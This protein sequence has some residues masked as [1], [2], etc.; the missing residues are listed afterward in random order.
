MK[1][2][3]KSRDR[4]I[5]FWASMIYVMVFTLVMFG[6][7]VSGVEV[8]SFWVIYSGTIGF[9]TSLGVANYIT[10]PKGTEND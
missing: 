10:T 3:L 6:F 4:K 9:L 2:S 8:I 1:A 5:A 7:H